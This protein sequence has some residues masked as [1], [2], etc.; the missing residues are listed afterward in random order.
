MCSFMFFLLPKGANPRSIRKKKTVHWIFIAIIFTSKVEATSLCETVHRA[1]T[2]GTS[3]Y[4]GVHIYFLSCNVHA[5]CIAIIWT[6][7]HAPLL[8]SVQWGLCGKK[9][10]LKRTPSNWIE[11]TQHL[12][13][14]GGGG[15]FILEKPTDVWCIRVYTMVAGVHMCL[16]RSNLCTVSTWHKVS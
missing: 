8:S 13:V 1:N 10:D 5:C 16:S 11:C 2:P 15:P 14:G 12:R 9:Q 3:W 7:C 4:N 6:R